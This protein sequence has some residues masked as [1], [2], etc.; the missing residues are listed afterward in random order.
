MVLGFLAI[1]VS[2]LALVWLAKVSRPRGVLALLIAAISPAWL[3]LLER[4]NIDQAILW[5]AIALVVIVTWKPTLLGWAIAALP[6]WV[7]GSWKYYPF[8][9]VVAFLPVLRIRRGWTVPT[10][11]LLAAI[12]YLFVFRDTVIQSLQSNSEMIGGIGRITLA[13]FIDGAA[14]NT[15]Q[16]WWAHALV[17]LMCLAAFIWGI[18]SAQVHHQLRPAPAINGQAMLAIAGATM[19]LS[20]LLLGGFG[21]IYKA[22]FLLLA[23]PMLSRIGGKENVVTWQSS[24]TMILLIIMAMTVTSSPLLGSIAALVAASFVLGLALMTL[25]RSDHPAADSS[26]SSPSTTSS[27][28]T[29]T[30]R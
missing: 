26:I 14:V 19:L 6:I 12:A 10:A 5:S 22:A 20:T 1:I 9:M 21:Y 30:V 25:L 16:S 8:A 15:Q 4:G 7:L 11:F 24:T 13:T 27:R 29:D 28:V 18:S 2:S 23:L 3:L 17:W